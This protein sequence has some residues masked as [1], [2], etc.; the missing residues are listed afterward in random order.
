MAEQI[1]VAGASP[2]YIDRGSGL[3]M[4]GYTASGVDLGGQAHFLDIPGDQNGGDQGPPIEIQYFGE[5]MDIRL[6]LTKYDP[7]LAELIEARLSGAEAGTPPTSGSLVFGS[8]GAMRLV[9]ASPSRPRNF[10]RAVPRGAF[11][12]NKGTRYS[13]FIVDFTAYKS[14]SGILWNT[15]TS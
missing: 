6:D 9:I 10:P 7:V 4:L 1:N 8:G 12:I 2:V 14:A 13:R 15:T 5:T 11:Q 3:Q